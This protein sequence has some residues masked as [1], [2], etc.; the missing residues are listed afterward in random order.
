MRGSG[1]DHANAATLYAMAAANYERRGLVTYTR[2]LS[3]KLTKTKGMPKAI[4]VLTQD[5]APERGSCQGR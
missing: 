1:D 5:S 3:E 2:H 4:T